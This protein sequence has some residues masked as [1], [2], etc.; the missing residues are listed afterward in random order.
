MLWL[1]RIT[2][3]PASVS[4]PTA[5]SKTSSG[6]MP[7]SWGLAISPDTGWVS[8]IISLEKGRRTLLSQ[9]RRKSVMISAIGIRSRPSGARCPTSPAWLFAGSSG[10]PS[11]FQVPLEPCQLPDLSLKRRPSASTM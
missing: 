3:N 9:S 11:P 1:L 4:A 10:E 6:R 7:F 5:R 2:A 8:P